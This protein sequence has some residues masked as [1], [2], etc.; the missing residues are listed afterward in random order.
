MTGIIRELGVVQSY[1]GL[2]IRLSYL[3]SLIAFNKVFRA[4]NEEFEVHDSM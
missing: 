4:E 2:H 3:D 1:L